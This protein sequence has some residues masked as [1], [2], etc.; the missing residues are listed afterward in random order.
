MGD[1]QAYRA[2]NEQVVGRGRRR[3]RAAG[4]SDGCAVVVEAAAMAVGAAAKTDKLV[5]WREERSSRQV[6]D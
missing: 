4:R 1:R 5:V 2:V 6:L 3:S